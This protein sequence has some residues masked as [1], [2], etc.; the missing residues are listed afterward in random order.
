MLPNVVPIYEDEQ[1]HSWIERLAIANGCTSI[2]QLLD[3][4]APSCKYRQITG[5]SYIASIFEAVDIE[6]WAE[7][8]VSHTEYALVSPFIDD[9][10]QM[11]LLDSAFAGRTLN[12]PADIKKLLAC[13]ECQKEN[14]Y[15]RVW[16]NLPGVRVCHKH[17]KTLIPVKS[18][19]E[20]VESSD[21]PVSIED[22]KY[23][24]YCHN[25]HSAQLPY[26]VTYI[27]RILDGWN[28]Y[29]KTRTTESAIKELMEKYPSVT[30]IPK[31]ISHSPSLPCGYTILHQCGNVIDI[32]HECGHRYCMTE[33]G[34]QTGFYCPSCSSELTE[35]ELVEGYI[36]AAGNDDYELVEP[37][38][39]RSNDIKLLHKTCG[40]VYEVSLN[41]FLTGTR[42]KC[43][44]SRTIETLRIQFASEYPDFTPV[45]RQGEKITIRHNSCGKEFAL[46]WKDWIRRPTCRHCAPL[47]VFSEDYMRQ[48]LKAIGL[49]LV[50]VSE[51]SPKKP[52]VT[53]TC[54][55]GHQSA[56][57]FYYIRTLGGCPQCL[58]SYAG[59][60]SNLILEY[61][62]ANYQDGLFFYDDLSSLFGTAT[63]K[64]S[65]KLLRDKNQIVLIT[66]GC[67]ALAGTN[68]EYSEKEI[69][70]QKYICRD[71]EAIGFLYG[72][73][74]AY[75]VLG[76]GEK[77]DVVSIATRKEAGPKGRLTH[78]SNTNLRLKCLP[79]GTKEDLEASQVADFVNGIYKFIKNPEQ[80]LETLY[81]YIDDR[82]ISKTEIV[83][84]VMKNNPL[85]GKIKK[86][87]MG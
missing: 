13:P 8:Y 5:R 38:Q 63:A 53:V 11:L 31:Q 42:C 25:L 35:G 83:R 36:K 59:S 70:K 67:Y 23:A 87:F 66:Q 62:K 34:L 79:P 61:L 43:E 18:S 81:Q 58:S 27:N 46:A 56:A 44:H 40:T 4:Y 71:G 55:H 16:H 7:F 68:R 9:Y 29:Q 54:D 2:N 64:R 77:P 39:S 57:G 52:K 85:Y 80:H 10:H 45:S 76:I 48:E 41:N 15:L 32:E 17:S 49:N 6:N 3:S 19:L 86:R 69:I 78:F 21:A 74:F 60:A 65:L 75:Y 33:K 24:E 73:S 82:N 28:Y 72:T 20:L 37:F 22:V 1:I 30:N 51:G 12:T 47:P 50:S 84:L 26:N 14:P